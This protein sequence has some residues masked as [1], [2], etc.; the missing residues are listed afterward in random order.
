[1]PGRPSARDAKIGEVFRETCLMGSEWIAG[2][3]VGCL[4]SDRGNFASIAMAMESSG[5]LEIGVS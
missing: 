2:G 5:G 3:A 1:M 4:R